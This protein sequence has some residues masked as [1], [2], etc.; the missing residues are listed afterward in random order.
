[1]AYIWNTLCEARVY[2]RLVSGKISQL[3]AYY[4]MSIFEIL[5]FVLDPRKT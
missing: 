4:G 3:K 1:M 5:Y 2:R